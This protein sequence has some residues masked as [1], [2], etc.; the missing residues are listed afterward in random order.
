MYK[1]SEVANLII[2]ATNRVT[3][4][5]RNLCYYMSIATVSHIERVDWGWVGVY[6]CPQPTSHVVTKYLTLTLES[7]DI[8]FFAEHTNKSNNNTP[9]P[10]NILR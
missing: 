4:S 2:Q 6:Q 1:V 9:Q 10:Q 7:Q 8:L 3:Q 5:N